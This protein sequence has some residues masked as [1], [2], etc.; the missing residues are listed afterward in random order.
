MKQEPRSRKYTLSLAQEADW[1]DVLWM[2]K[3]FHAES[4][5]SDIPFS[6]N[7]VWGLFSQYLNSDK[8]SL[9]CLLL[10]DGEETCGIIFCAVTE[11]YFSETKAASEIIWWVHP[12][13]RLKRG[14]LLLFQAYEFWAN[15]VGAKFACAVSTE[16]TTQLDRFYK[17]SGYSLYESTYVKKLKES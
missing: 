9:L 12:D 10:K 14:S 15:K 17:R 7:K 11:L 8:T 6:E 16:G 13:H 1:D 4:P 2:S 3:S 5:Y